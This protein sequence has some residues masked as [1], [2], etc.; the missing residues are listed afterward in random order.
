ML[1]GTYAGL[2]ASI[3][4]F[5]NRSDLTSTIPDFIVIAE[6]QMARRFVGRQREGKPIPRR[7]ILRSDAS[8]TLAAEYVAVPTD[9]FGP[10]ILELTGAD[11]TLI[12]MDYLDPVN[13]D[14]EKKRAYW[15]GNPKFY[16]VINGE[17]KIYPVADQAYTGEMTYV[18]RLAAA[19]TATN[20]I[21]TDYP[22]AYLYGALTASAPYLKDDGRVT[23][24]GTLFQAA[25][26]DICMADP[27]PSDKSKLRTEV[28]L[29]QRYTRSGSYNINTDT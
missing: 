7:L 11:G 23:V 20:F 3:A 15:V 1:D 12:E 13:L 8:F 21:L 6:A 25:I 18:K 4:D 27:M 10:L 22:D 28:A 5:L 2:K 26:D 19:S 24:W 16:T 29:L 17:L 14:H 9:F